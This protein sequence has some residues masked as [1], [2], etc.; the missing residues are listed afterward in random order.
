[1]LYITSRELYK[2]V[3]LQEIWSEKREG[4]CISLFCV[5]PFSRERVGGQ[6]TSQTDLI[7]NLPDPPLTPYTAPAMVPPTG[8]KRNILPYLTISVLIFKRDFFRSGIVF[9]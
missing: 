8:L 6:Q 9:I 7:Q 3:V 4:G 1:M 5:T 2:V